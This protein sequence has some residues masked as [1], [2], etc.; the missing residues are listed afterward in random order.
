MNNQLRES[1]VSLLSDTITNTRIVSDNEIIEGRELY[2]R[3]L[4]DTNYIDTIKTD[5]VNPIID[6]YNL[7]FNR[8]TLIKV[9][10]V[11]K[12]NINNSYNQYITTSIFTLGRA[13]GVNIMIDDLDVS[14]IH[15]FG[16]IVED[17]II[18]IDTWSL[19]GTKIYDPSSD[20]ITDN[21]SIIENRHLLKFNKDERCILEL[22]NYLVII[23]PDK[24]L[25]NKL[26]IIC[27]TAPRIIRNDCGH[28]V[29]CQ[30]CNEKLKK[31]NN[32]CPI[33]L[34]IIKKSHISNCI[35]TYQSNTL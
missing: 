3:C 15:L 30:C 7:T 27:M 20:D 12:N 33:C 4:T 31:Y 26:C 18:I 11:S 8:D 6:K 23:N 21:V 13:P 22:K 17:N 16:L 5:I 10:V 2:I 1:C 32:K 19:F 35:N 14:R 24:I 29:L 34:Q 25:N 9:R 28:G